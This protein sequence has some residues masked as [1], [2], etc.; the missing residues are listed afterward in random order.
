MAIVFAPKPGSRLSLADAQTVGEAIRAVEKKYGAYH[1]AK[2]FLRYCRDPK[3][4]VHPIWLKRK[5]AL[6]KGAG[7]DAASYLRRSVHAI[8]ATGCDKNYPLF[9]AAGVTLADSN[10]KGITFRSA[11][12]KRSP[13]LLNQMEM[14][15][16]TSVRAFA[17]AFADQ[18][19]TKRMKAAVRS[20]LSEF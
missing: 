16:K 10:G 4:A 6:E 5:R 17:R 7:R 14:Q 2:D 11:V 13:V 12:M 3:N 8:R 15:F 18:A 20:V 19:G 9:S 1:T